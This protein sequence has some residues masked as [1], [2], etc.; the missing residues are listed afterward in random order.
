MS[1]FAVLDGTPVLSAE[2]H[3]FRVPPE[4]WPL[5]LVRLRQM[6]AN[7]VSTYVPWCWHEVQPGIFDFTGVTDPRRHVLHFIRLCGTLGLR[8]ILKPG[9][10]IDAE[11]LGG[12]PLWLLQ[13]HPEIYARRAN[14]DIWRRSNSNAPHVCSVHPVYLDAVRRWIDAFSTAALP[15]QHPSGPIIAIQ[16]DNGTPDDRMRSADAE[17]DPRL[18]LD[19]NAYVVDHLWHSFVGEGAP[20]PSRTLLPPQTVD[21]LE[22][23]LLLETFTDQVY[24]R[25][26]ATVVDLLRDA[27]WRVPISHN[28]PAAPSHRWSTIVDLPA[29]ARATDWLG[30][31]VYAKDVMAPFVSAAAYTLSFEEYVHYGF[32]LPRLMATLSRS[33]PVFVTEISAAQDF[34][35]ATP[36]MGGAQA[37]NVYAAV[38]AH[39][40]NPAISA[41][42]RWAMEAPIQPD[43]GIRRCFW[44][45]K[46]LF[47]LL[48]A[49]GEDFN[50]AVFPAD[51][52]IGYSH[53]PERVAQHNG[54]AI[55]SMTAGCNMGQRAQALAQRLVQ[56]GI[57]FHI[58]DLD[59]ASPENLAIYRLILV[60]SAAL[61][62][63][64]TQQQLVTCPNLA[65]VGE[66]LPSFDEHLEPCDLLRNGQVN[67]PAEQQI[68]DIAPSPVAPKALELLPEDVSG[69]QIMELIEQRGGYAR[70]GW[71]DV[72]DIDVTVRYGNR[73]TFVCVANRRKE[74]YRGILTYRSVDG[75]LQHLHTGIGGLKIGLM[76]VCGDEIVGCAMAGN[77]SE[78]AWFVRGAH[79][80]IM[81]SG[82]AGVAAPCDG[83]MLLSAVQS[84]RFQLRRPEGWDGLTPYRLLVSGE[85]L[86]ADIH[87]EGTHLSLPYVSE[88]EYGVTDSYLLLP[89]GPTPDLVRAGLR[90][91][92]LGRAHM[93]RAA[94]V[95]L[96]DERSAT[97]Q[98]LAKAFGVFLST[99]ETLETLAD[100]PFTVDAFAAAWQHATDVC[101]PVVVALMQGVARVRSDR[102]IGDLDDSRYA[103]LEELL[104]AVLE[105]VA[106]SRLR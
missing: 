77:G 32:W 38:Q 28:L 21:D 64:A 53:I 42:P 18:R 9:P 52:A 61:M 102:L 105:C 26:L 65:L 40:D 35:V 30:F 87:I 29:L 99:A 63:R 45:V 33:F 31:K 22:R 16:V 97:V 34:Y 69:E 59:S 60:P 90:T 72:H 82:G 106:R 11:V 103:A 83:G 71:T 17:R 3:Y 25:A 12:I 98:V 68:S 101:E 5:L 1:R 39:P 66:V 62:A 91:L 36:L 49:A 27:G 41:L 56:A 50:A 13:R 54:E 6:G 15:F 20:G 104:G 73:Y 79:S 96:P 84:G 10:F 4:S 76:L 93:L 85:V 43:G 95:P 24:A 94:I 55:Q 92:I 2:L 75:S 86:P 47:T 23:Y 57:P 100:Q 48:A 7:T 19:Y 81:F 58:V 80:S 74:S 67:L 78:G 70:Y 37:I 46:T 14:G 44:N 51:V 8:L 88:D 89:A